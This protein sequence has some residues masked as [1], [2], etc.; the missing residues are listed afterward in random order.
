MHNS[1]FDGQ[2]YAEHQSGD[3]AQL[4]KML[5]ILEPHGIFGSN[6]AYLYILIVLVCKTGMMFWRKI[7]RRPH[8]PT[9]NYGTA[10]TDYILAK[11]STVPV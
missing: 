10:L 9:T 3:Q 5:I 8:L 11:P 6:F 1:R 7:Q 2:G 4:L